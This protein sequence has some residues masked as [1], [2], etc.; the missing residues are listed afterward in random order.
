MDAQALLAPD[1]G[2]SLGQSRAHVFDLLRAAPSPAGVQE[3]ADRAGL[4]P[5]T[6]RFHL[7]ALVDAGLAARAPKES[8]APGRPS[9]AYRAVEGGGPAGR[10]RYR[11]LAEMLTSL[12]AGVMPKPGEAAAKPAASGD[13][14]SPSSRPHTSGWARV[15]P[16]RD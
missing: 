14:T 8:T 2:P 3:I 13:A 11:L 12:I 15:R 10:R 5:N 6:A 4:H 9:M 16:S 1:A 7:H